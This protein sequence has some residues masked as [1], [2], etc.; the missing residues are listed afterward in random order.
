MQEVRLVQLGDFNNATLHNLSGN[1]SRIQPY[2]RIQYDDED[3]ASKSEK[4][5]D[6]SYSDRYFESVIAQHMKRQSRSGY[7][8]GI[9]AAPIA[10]ASEEIF[11]STR[12]EYSIISTNELSG[13]CTSTVEEFLAYCVASSLLCRDLDFPIHSETRGCP[14]DYCDD[15]SDINRGMATCQLCDEC[16][17]VLQ[18][19]A[20]HQRVSIPEIAA[21][22][23]MFDSVAKRRVCFVLMPFREQFDDVYRNIKGVVES[24]GYE[25]VRADEIFKPMNIMRIVV[26]LIHRADILIADVTGR[27][28]NVFYELG[29]SHAIGKRTILLTQRDEDVPFDVKQ[30]Q[31]VRYK[32]GPS[33]KRTLEHAL[34]R[35]L[36]PRGQKGVLL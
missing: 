5:R 25:C 2:F 28:A 32:K 29:Y 24:N 21:V 27:N 30:Q 17:S 31:Y 36:Q 20:E 13:Y 4:K 19:A 1:L 9:T 3:A 26:E 12:T 35:Y 15:R 18:S 16:D 14:N 22:K 34:T 6:G 11:W 23:R 7:P 33:M 8:I 10:P